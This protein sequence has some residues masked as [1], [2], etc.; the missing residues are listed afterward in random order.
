LHKNQFLWVALFCFAGP[1]AWSQ[2]AAPSAPTVAAAPTPSAAMPTNP[3][4]LMKLAAEVNGLHSDKLTP[5]HLKASFQLFDF[6]GKPSEKGTYEEFWVSPT[7]YKRIYTSPSLTQTEWATEKGSYFLPGGIDPRKDLQ[8]LIRSNFLDP[9]KSVGK[10]KITGHPLTSGTVNLFCV[11]VDPESSAPPPSV[12]CFEKGEPILRIVTSL[13]FRSFSNQVIRFQNHYLPKSL[14]VTDYGRPRLQLQLD[15]VD[16]LTSVDERDFAPPADAESEENRPKLASSPGMVPGRVL[17][18][19]FPEYPNDARLLN[20]TVR[21]Y[22]TVGKNGRVLNS[23]VISTSDALLIPSTVDA[24][25]K[26]K[27]SPFLLNGVPVESELTIEITRRK[28]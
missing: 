6:A 15:S 18:S 2:T 4:E 27:F 5:W 24:V 26:Y 22:I 25:N 23:H 9:L 20:G 13:G 16:A 1:D 12:F 3:A 10:G 28:D 17:H 21:L 19:V 7:K 8:S 11:S 14:E